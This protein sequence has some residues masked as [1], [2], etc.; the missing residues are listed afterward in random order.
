MSRPECVIHPPSPPTFTCLIT[1]CARD[2]RPSNT[3]PPP[4]SKLISINSSF[5]SAPFFRNVGPLETCRQLSSHIRPS[6]SSWTLTVRFRSSTRH[7]SRG[8]PVSTPI[9]VVSSI[10]SPSNRVRPGV[11][12]SIF[13]ILVDP[14]PGPTTEIPIRSTRFRSRFLV[15]PDPTYRCS[16]GSGSRWSSRLS[17]FHPNLGP[18]DVL[19]FE[20]GSHGYSLFR[21]SLLTR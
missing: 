12:W 16:N 20:W 10:F 17:S 19:L 14:S 15:R 2:K 11:Y 9:S 21:T 7:V 13:M 3:G 1:F 6:L 5:V 4:L 18:C 8:V